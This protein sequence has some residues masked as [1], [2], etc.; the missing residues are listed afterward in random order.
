M[1]AKCLVPVINSTYGSMFR[2]DAAYMSRDLKQNQ[3]KS[4]T[5]KTSELF[6]CWDGSRPLSVFLLSD[7]GDWRRLQII[8]GG[9]RCGA[10]G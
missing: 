3:T 6:F 7:F 2:T 1:K 8:I 4:L 9:V 10:V 5:S